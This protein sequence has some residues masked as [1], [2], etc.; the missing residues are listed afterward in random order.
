MSTKQHTV[1]A[2]MVGKLELISESRI[3][4]EPKRA[5]S[6]RNEPNVAACAFDLSD[7]TL[8]AMKSTVGSVLLFVV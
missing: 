1:D 6:R 5:Q 8:Q 4:R 2:M 7:N 3:E